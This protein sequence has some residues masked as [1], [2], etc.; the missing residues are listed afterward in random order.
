MTVGSFPVCC[1]D[2]SCASAGCQDFSLLGK[3][4]G[5]GVGFPCCPLP[6]RG[7]PVPCEQQLEVLGQHP[8]LQMAHIGVAVLLDPS[9]LPFGGNTQDS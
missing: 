8:E 5:A 1:A 3:A 4:A 2:R 7:C 9:K 6:A